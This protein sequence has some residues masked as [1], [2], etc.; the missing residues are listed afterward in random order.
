MFALFRR[1]NENRD[2]L[3]T[4]KKF[5]YKAESG[6]ESRNSHVL[7]T[8]KTHGRMSTRK[9]TNL[10]N[11]VFGWA[12]NSDLSTIKRVS[13]TTSVILSAASP[14]WIF[15]GKIWVTTL[16]RCFWIMGGE[17]APFR[18]ECSILFLVE[19][20]CGSEWLLTRRLEK[21]RGGMSRG[22]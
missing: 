13:S 7:Y 17:W 16:F 9:Y 22:T 18:N 3:K 1:G 10:P 20:F 6:N 19:V 21:S 5:I 8:W 11:M 15:L 2:S 4:G 14:P 12:I